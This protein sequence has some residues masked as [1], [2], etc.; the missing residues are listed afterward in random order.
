MI[1]DG[2]LRHIKDGKPFLM[3]PRFIQLFLNKQLEG[4]DKPLNFLP[5]VVLPQK[6]FT[7]MS[8][9]SNKFSGRITPLTPHM[10][11]I[12]AAVEDEHS[13]HK[14][15]PELTPS[16]SNHG[17]GDTYGEKEDSPTKS[18][19][20]RSDFPNDYTPTD[21]VQTSRGDEGNLDLY[22]LNREVIRLKKEKAKQATDI[23]KLKAKLK[24]LV[25]M[26]KP[27]VTKHRAFVKK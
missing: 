18:A 26:V 27:V 1:F 25:K 7:F 5:T 19:A 22:G 21:E 3:Y 8:K 12:A 2:M 15:E 23:L 17:V 20:K 16:P 9:S 10:L 13:V 6:V 14:E 11:E 24:K 4:I